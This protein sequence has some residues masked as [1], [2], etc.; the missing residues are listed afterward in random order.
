MEGIF[1][2]D[3]H[4]SRL[5]G[6]STKTTAGPINLSNLVVEGPAGKGRPNS[7]SEEE[8]NRLLSVYYSRPYSLRALANMFG[9]SRMTIWRIVNSVQTAQPIQIT[10]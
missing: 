3:A 6:Q 8:I 10:G 7:L 5:Q 9:V 2:S 4:Q 1:F